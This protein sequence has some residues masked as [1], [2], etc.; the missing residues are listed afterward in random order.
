[1]F[2]WVKKH[3]QL[4]VISIRQELDTVS[5]D[6][7]TDGGWEERE[8]KGTIDRALRDPP[9]QDRNC[10]TSLHLWQPTAICLVDMTYTISALFL[11]YHNVHAGV[12]VKLGGKAH[13][14]LRKSQ[15]VQGQLPDVDQRR[16][17][18]HFEFWWEQSLWNIL[19]DMI[20]FLQDWV[21]IDMAT[22]GWI[23]GDIPTR[24]PFAETGACPS[25]VC[26]NRGPDYVWTPRRHSF[27]S[28]RCLRHPPPPIE[29]SWIRSCN[30]Q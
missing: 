24:T 10:P 16:L 9:H 30:R 11:L 13:Q 2:T 7:I 29:S 25:Y 8:H 20:C 5:I 27:S 19:S 17:E 21:F 1:M 22:Q 26:R 12:E 28:S 3:V 4:S 14:T 23:Y 15:E 6:N 18:C